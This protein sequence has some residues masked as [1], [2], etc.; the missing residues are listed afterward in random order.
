[1]NKFPIHLD[2][3]ARIG[4]CAEVG[5]DLTIDTDSAGGDQF[6]AMATRSDTRSG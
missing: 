3:I 4:L 1:V 5:A 6:I 2:V